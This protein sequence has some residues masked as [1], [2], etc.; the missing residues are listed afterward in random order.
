MAQLLALDY[1][2]KRT[3]IAYTD[4][5]QMIASGLKTLATKELFEFLTTYLQKNKVEGLVIGYPTHLDGRDTDATP[6]VRALIEKI[7]KTFPNLKIMLENE[8]FTS[9][10]ALQALTFS[11]KK[12]KQ[13]NKALI[14]QVS[15][16]IILQAYLDKKK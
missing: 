11:G 1:G 16:T 8:H 3:G 6:L 2:A 9:K 12:I 5:G 15:A 13:H 14:D 10:M 4:E 7:K